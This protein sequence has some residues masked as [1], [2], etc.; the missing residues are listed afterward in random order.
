MTGLA[1]A[2]FA[3]FP[4]MPPRLLDVSCDNFGGEC[5]ASR[6]RPPGGSFGFIDTLAQYGGLWSFG[7]G[8]MAN[9]SNQY[10]AMPSL[11]IGWSTWCAVAMWP[12]LRRR[13]QRV[14]VLLYPLVTLFCIVVTANHFFLDGA[15]GLI[16]FGVGLLVG[17]GMHRVNQDRLDRKW[18]RL[19]GVRGHTTPVPT[20]ELSTERETAWRPA[21]SP[22][23]PTSA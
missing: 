3:L 4:L 16:V 13:W 7:S 12:L 14:A 23:S 6:F 5:I 20:T 1:I 2:G 21:A 11:H 19:H 15:G 18:E 17:W 22:D 10:A 8:G 9:V